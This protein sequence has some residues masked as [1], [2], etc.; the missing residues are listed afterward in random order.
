MRI[1]VPAGQGQGRATLAG[2]AIARPQVGASTSLLTRY[3]AQ[4]PERVGRRDSAF[5]SHAAEV[6]KSKS[7]PLWLPMLLSPAEFCRSP[8]GVG[9]VRPLPLRGTNNLSHQEKEYFMRYFRKLKLM[10]TKVHIH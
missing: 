1:Q 8:R 3:P 6:G 10:Q 9:Q 4:W 2:K 7:H 5:P